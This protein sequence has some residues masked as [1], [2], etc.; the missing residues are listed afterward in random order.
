MMESAQG[1][2]VSGGGVP[3]LPHQR[4]ET[5]GGPGLPEERVVEKLDSAG[6]LI[7]IPDQHLVKETLKLRRHFGVLQFG[8]RHVSDP[9]H[10][11]ERRLVEERRLSIH[12][13]DDHDAKGPDVNFRAIRK[14]RDDLRGHP[15][16]GAHQ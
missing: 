2:D 14:S 1:C 10:G 4:H 11:L 16:R 13:L 15:V 3:V 9:P 8:R 6:P 12:H 5:G 7:G